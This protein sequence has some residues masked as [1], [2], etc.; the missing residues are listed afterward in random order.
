MELYDLLVS[1]RVDHWEL[2]ELELEVRNWSQELKQRPWRNFALLVPQSCSV[3]FLIQTRITYPGLVLFPIPGG[4]N[5]QSNLPV[6]LMETFSQ[7]PFHLLRLLYFL[8]SW[9]KI[10]QNNWFL[11]N[12]TQN[13]SL[14]NSNVSFLAFP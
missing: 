3:C 8:S 11:V 13:V 4:R 1:I 7:L 2:S 14:L 9:Q 6:N 12:F 10:N 5:P